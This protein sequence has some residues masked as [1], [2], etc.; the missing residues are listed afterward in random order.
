MYYL[1]QGMTR[2]G[3]PRYYLARE[4]QG[5]PL[6]Q[7]PEG[8]EIG[9][10]VNGQVFLAKKRPAE[11]QA[12]EKAIV[13]AAIARHPQSRSYRVQV[14]GKQIVIYEHTGPKVEDLSPLFRRLGGVSQRQVDSVREF[15][16]ETARFSP[17]LRITLKDKDARVF[18]AERRSYLSSMADWIRIGPE[19]SLRQLAQRL[20]PMLGTDALFEVYL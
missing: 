20:I 17:V 10:S 3:K 15:L 18:F 19:G 11:I 13:E 9:E 2:G 4:P 14:K 7:I 6:D 8:Y 12:E 16:D 5:D 1:C